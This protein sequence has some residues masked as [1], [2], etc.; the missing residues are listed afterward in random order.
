MK[1]ALGIG[2]VD[3]FIAGA[4]MITKKL[5]GRVQFEDM[6]GFDALMMSEEAFVL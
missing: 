6:G 2:D 5:G 1:E 3:G 4:N